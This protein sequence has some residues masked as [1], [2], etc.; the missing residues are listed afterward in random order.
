MHIETSDGREKLIILMES[1]HL[2]S[3]TWTRIPICSSSPTHCPSLIRHAVP[4]R[5]HPHFS[6]RRWHFQSQGGIFLH[7]LLLGTTVCLLSL[8][9]GASNGRNLSTKIASLSPPPP[10]F[11][12]RRFHFVSSR[13]RKRAKG[14]REREKWN[15]SHFSQSHLFI[16][17]SQTRM[18]LFW[19]RTPISY[20]TA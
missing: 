14:E 8:D 1:P 10:C 18:L 15:V 4:G 6:R 2:Y 20:Q 12:R 3:V 17:N 5:H 11:R 9:V 13:R 16:P 7:L 19:I